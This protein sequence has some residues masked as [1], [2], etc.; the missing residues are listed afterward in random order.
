[1]GLFF[2]NVSFLIAMILNRHLKLE[3][4]LMISFR[5]FTLFLRVLGLQGDGL[6]AKE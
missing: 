5:R 3:G 2:F 1:M 6:E 4:I